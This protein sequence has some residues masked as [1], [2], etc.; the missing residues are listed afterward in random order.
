MKLK[1]LTYAFA[2]LHSA[3]SVR[4]RFNVAPETTPSL[5]MPTTR[6]NRVKPPSYP[7]SNAQIP[8]LPKTQQTQTTIEVERED[9]NIPFNNPPEPDGSGKRQPRAR[10]RQQ[11]NTVALA[12]SSAN[13]DGKDVPPPANGTGTRKRVQETEG[14]TNGT[15]NNAALKKAKGHA[16]VA[17]QPS[18][19]AKALCRQKRTAVV[20]PR[21]PLP[22]RPGRN[23]HPAKP[24]ATRRTSQEV[25]AEREAKKR[26]MEEKIRE[27]ERAK[28]FLALMN[29]NEDRNNEELLT[30]N[31]QRLSAAIRKR[32]RK[33]HASTD[34][35][36]DGEDFDFDAVEDGV[37]SD[38][39]S[40]GPAKAK[41]R[42]V[43]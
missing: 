36:D 5:S 8:E 9:S 38:E 16:D 13:D 27:G 29:I 43:S 41:G 15:G 37:D 17:S 24:T 1:S 20:D 31:P 40:V 34:D 25:A 22:D 10:R 42:T 39:S 7:K 12:H 3:T 18:A 19:K 11:P 26:A 23:V 2:V 32:G 6:S 21:D 4:Y 35:S 30:E 14:T 33:H 28:E